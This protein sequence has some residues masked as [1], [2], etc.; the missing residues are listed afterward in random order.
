MIKKLSI[1]TIL[2]VLLCFTIVGRA[3]AQTR[4]PGVVQGNVFTYDV[5]S[6]WSSSDQSA[7]IPEN[8]LDINKTEFYRVTITEVSGAEITTQNTWHFTNGTETSTIGTVNV[9]AGGSSGGFWAIVAANLRANDLVHP[10]GQDAITV[11]ETIIRAYPGGERETNHFTVNYQGDDETYGYYTEEGDC[12]FDR[13]TGM[14]VELYDKASFVSA[15]IESAVLWKI[16][17]SNVWVVPEFP[18]VLILPLFMIATLLAAIVYKKKRA[19]STQ[20]LVPPL[21]VSSQK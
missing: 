10:Y 13:K 12:Y 2:L 15:N 5:T 19:S 1:V 17:D 9:E 6:F 18:S 16:K 3:W 21:L 11:N 7:T 14:L 20:R 4:V 8:L